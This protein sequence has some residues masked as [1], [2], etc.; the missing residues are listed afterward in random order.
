MEYNVSVLNTA[1]DLKGLDT[2][3]PSILTKHQTKEINP[4]PA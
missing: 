2:I 4:N 3:C 1:T